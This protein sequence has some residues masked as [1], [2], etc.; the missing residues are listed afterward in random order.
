MDRIR[1]ALGR[2]P[3]SASEYEPLHPDEATALE[4]SA[5]LD[6]QSEVP[7]SWMEYSIF[8]VLG[9]AMLWAW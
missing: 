1:S 4:G 7:F 6:G 2:R 5:V 9:M 8:A 3:S